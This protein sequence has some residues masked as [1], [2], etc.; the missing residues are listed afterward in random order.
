M[1]AYSLYLVLI[2]GE[3]VKDFESGRNFSWEKKNIW[4]EFEF[5]FEYLLL[6]LLYYGW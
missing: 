2:W 5:E 1:E 6:V 3:Y 4:G